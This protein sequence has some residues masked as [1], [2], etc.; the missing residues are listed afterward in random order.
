MALL[1]ACGG[2]D[3]I[4]PNPPSPPPPPPPPGEVWSSVAQRSWTVP[5]ASEAYKCHTILVASDEYFT[6]FRLASPSAAQTEVFLTMRPTAVTTGDQDC[7]LGTVS[8][9]EAIYAAA[10]GTTP[11]TFAGGKGVHIAAGQY[12]T[13]LIHIVNTMASSITASST[14]EGRVAA[15][16][17][18]TTPIDMFFA[19]RLNFT[20]SLQSDSVDINAGCS[21][22]NDSHLLAQIPIMRGH[23]IHE[24]TFVTDDG[25]THSL[26]DSSFDPLHVVYSSLATDFAVAAAQH[27]RLNV[28]CSYAN[29]TGA[30]VNF[31]ESA[32]DEL[33]LAGIY[34]YPP[35][36]PTSASPLECALG[37]DI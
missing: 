29:S 32:Q 37:Q 22:V 2:G 36:P 1:A 21:A 6:G 12:V 35:K 18:V 16:S 7:D 4:S 27:P 9:G 24:R 33:C 25:G 23:G 17:A 26:F 28:S 14:I 20:F 5:G 15:A 30:V 3:S 8:G 13:L 11:V 10:Q 34:R 31:G 19:G